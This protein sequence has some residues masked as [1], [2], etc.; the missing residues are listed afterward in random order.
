MVIAGTHPGRILLCAGAKFPQFQVVL[1]TVT[2]A[3]CR[4]NTRADGVIFPVAV[5]VVDALVWFQNSAELLLY[6][7]S[8]RHLPT[9]GVSAR[10][11]FDLQVAANSATLAN[12]TV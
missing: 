8:V 7:Q 4:C 9:D 3:A 1:L 11:H 5:T 6:C 10:T 12:R 2:A